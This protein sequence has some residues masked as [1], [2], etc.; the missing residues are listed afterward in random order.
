[1]SEELEAAELERL[2]GLVRPD[3]DVP[4]LLR[5]ALALLGRG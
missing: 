4:G 5:Q 3:A 2:A 1:M